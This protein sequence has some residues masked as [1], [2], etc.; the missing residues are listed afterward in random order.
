MKG[1]LKRFG[2]E[3][4][5]PMST[6]LE[7]GREFQKLSEEETPVEM[8]KYQQMIGSMMHVKTATRPDLE[9]P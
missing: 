4:C 7:A 1:I 2:M 9:L 5:K 6:P 8:K 3:D